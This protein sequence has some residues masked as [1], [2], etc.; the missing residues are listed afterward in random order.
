MGCGIGGSTV[1]VITKIK[2]K[3]NL[4]SILYSTVLI[5]F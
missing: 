3:R 1:G 5:L 2:L 4:R